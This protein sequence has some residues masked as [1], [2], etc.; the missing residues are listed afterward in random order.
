MEQNSNRPAV[1]LPDQKNY[2]YTYGQAYQLAVDELLSTPDLAE[3]CAK[4]SSIFVDEGD[5]KHIQLEYLSHDY[6]IE[7]PEVNIRRTIGDEA[8][9]L[10][11]KILI[12][13]YLNRAAGTEPSENLIAFKE[14]SE[15]ASYYPTFRKRAIQP[16]IDRFGKNPEKLI[17]AALEIG[18]IRS[19]LG[20]A[21]VSIETFVRV[22]I[23]LVI[24][25]GD[26]EFPPDANIL[27][28]AN[29]KDYLS[30]ED[31]IILCQT[32]AWKLVKLAK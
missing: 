16:L 15:V 21:S 32:I 19:D 30:L 12:L 8:V 14:I 20:D 3:K 7:L 6:I 17:S 18:G 11:D 5:K 22:P 23:T 10:R 4:S 29:I 13:H 25:G 27:F 2:D 28:D 1:N 26:D 24:W 9:E 31:I